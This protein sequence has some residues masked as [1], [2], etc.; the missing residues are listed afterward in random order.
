MDVW[1]V[2]CANM[3]PFLCPQCFLVLSHT[4]QES[5]RRFPRGLTESSWM[6]PA[7]AWASGPSYSTGS[8]PGNCALTHPSS[9][10]SWR[11]WVV[12]NLRCC[13][14]IA[15]ALQQILFKS[16]AV[17]SSRTLRISPLEYHL[18][19]T[20]IGSTSI[21]LTFHLFMS[22][23]NYLIMSFSKVANRKCV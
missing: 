10:A 1:Y 12:T 17:M 5:G 15:F 16:H 19:W 9:A 8:R 4:G 14:V 11:L 13:H 3:F 23:L 21:N 20:F 7:A 18:Q 6:P 22:L 2:A